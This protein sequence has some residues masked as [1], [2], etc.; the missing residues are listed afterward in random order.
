MQL[1]RKYRAHAMTAVLA[2]FFVI[3]ATPS[4]TSK[5]EPTGDLAAART[6]AQAVD[7][8]YNWLQFGGDSRH[9]SN[10][11]LETKITAQN[12]HGLTQLFKIALPETIEGA[13]VVLTNVTTSS[14]LHDVAFMTTRSGLILAIDAYSGATL[15]SAQPSSANITM[16][17][18]AIDPSLAYVYSAGLDGY[19]HKYAVGTGTEVRTGGWPELSTL[20]TNVEKDGT[21]ITIASSGGTNYLYMGV[22]GYIGDAGEY[23]GH[24][25]TINLS[26]GAQTV[27]NAMCSNQAVHFTLGGNPDCA[28]GQKSGI[29][30]KA[31]LTFDPVTNRLYV[32]TGNGTFNPSAFMWGDTILALN[33]DGTGANGGPVDSYTPTNFQS[34][35]NSDLDLGSTNV[36][37]LANNGSKYPHL[38]ALSG[39]DA[40]LRLVNLDNMSGQGGP[41]KVGGEISSTPLPTGGEVQNPTATWMNPADGTTWI[42][43]VSPT[44]GMNALRLAVDGGGNPSLV[45]VWQAGGGGGG[46]FVANNVLYYSANNNLRALDPTTGTQL[47]NNT[48]VGTIHWQAP[49]VVNGVLYLGDNGRRLTAFSLPSSVV[50]AGAPDSGAPD[51]GPGETAL[52]RNGWI[53]SA[54]LSA[55]GD[56]PANAIDGNAG[57]RWSTGA[58]MAN[59]MSFNVDMQSPQ[60]FDQITM[61]AAGSNGDYPRGY[62]IFVSSDGVNFGN[63]VASGNGTDQL[64][65]AHFASQTARYFQIVQTGAAPNWWSIAELNVYSSGSTPPPPPPPPPGIL[66]VNAGGP[67]VSPFIADNG[68]TGGTLINHANTI[69]L[70]G[71][72]NAAPQAVYQ[73]AR[74]G[75]F[76]YDLGGFTPGSGH[77]IRL[78]FAETYFAT[79]GSRTFNVSING[80]Q[81]L[82]NFDIYATAGAKNKALVESFSQN[83]SASGD[84]VIQFTSIIN[85][86]LLSGIEIQ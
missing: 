36:L 68:F 84:Y 8:K 79:A 27:F 38:A 3:E 52:S 43:V 46:A 21:A 30:A 74:I 42:F 75:D 4:C 56:V 40:K 57:T 73:T 69:D 64:V 41:G 82:G 65:T 26:T 63:A 86:S 58:A 80:T 2:S 17:S 11:T 5:K 85:N 28:N 47:W 72:I 31:G 60:T 16:S 7:A 48:G 35:Q 54:S 13:P 33:A 22:G 59:G 9:G 78:H 6:T 53:A 81:V 55:G 66:H 45:P 70:S 61:D 23:Q 15:W 77:S 25:T 67:A 19:I 76:S 1:L 83:A 34:L 20:K 14:G 44:N 49:V 37:I 71:A 18:P 62:Q 12:V 51:A 39:K 24:V 10:N 32:G 29:W 50:D